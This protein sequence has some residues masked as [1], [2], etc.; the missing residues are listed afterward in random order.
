MPVLKDYK[1]EHQFPYKFHIKQKGIDDM[2]GINSETSTEG[3]SLPTLLHSH[4]IS[5]ASGISRSLKIL[6]TTS[7]FFHN[8]QM[9][10]SGFKINLNFLPAFRSLQQFARFKIK[11]G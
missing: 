11:L 3:P 7:G 6:R 4:V 2:G 1:I 8:K 5:E 10:S 9:I